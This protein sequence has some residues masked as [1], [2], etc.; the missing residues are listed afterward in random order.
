MVVS[1]SF[2][3]GGIKSS[4]NWRVEGSMVGLTAY[5]RVVFGSGLKCEGVPEALEAS[6]EFEPEYRYRQ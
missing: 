4:G 5:Y 2:D 3:G 1:H 6:R